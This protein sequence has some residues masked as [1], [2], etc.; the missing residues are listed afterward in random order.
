MNEPA[1]QSPVIADFDALQEFADALR[2]HAPEIGRG[3][4]VLRD[5]PEDSETI[6]D[7]FRRLHNIKGDAALCRLD[8]AVGLAHP[9]E[10]LLARVR[11]GEF[12][13]SARLAEI[14]LLTVDRLELAVE[15]LLGHRS[16][17]SLALRT[18]TAGLEALATTA[19][20]D[21]DTAA[22]LLIA[23]V[24]GFRPSSMASDVTGGTRR[25]RADTGT[26]AAD[27]N[28]FRTLALQLETRS[29][30]FRGRTGRI[31]RLALETN[32][33]AGT[34]VAPQQ[35]EAAIYLHDLGMMFLPEAVWLKVGPLTDSD[36]EALR[37]HPGYAA[38]LLKRMPGWEGAALIVAQHHEMPDGGGYPHGLNHDRI[39]PG[40]HLLAIID[41]FEAVTLKHEHRGH[42]RSV[43]R[44]AA[45][46]NANQNQFAAEWISP[47]NQV[48]RQ[49]IEKRTDE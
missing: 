5:H 12:T 26:P 3:I 7:V 40:A 36:R 17:A 6:A 42:N 18:L 16:T 30:L 45:E 11:A 4:G 41:A 14:L 13:L 38:E 39:T 28:L 22:G 23:Q 29:E 10:T 48:I 25:V 2:D 47:F 37:A 20:A 34:P 43:L 19:A 8:F 9:A 15:A 35:L 31:L 1:L 27:L 46:I 24:T 49:I 21:L 44:A 33:V 32:R